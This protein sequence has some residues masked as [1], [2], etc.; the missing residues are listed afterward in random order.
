VF[1]DFETWKP[2]RWLEADKEQKEEMK[3]WFWAFGSGAR[4]C[5]GV[6]FATQGTYLER[7]CPAIEHTDHFHHRN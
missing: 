7:Y 3:K 1:P 4:M 2:E 5:L 6:Y